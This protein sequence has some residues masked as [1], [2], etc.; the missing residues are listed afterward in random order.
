MVISVIL[1]QRFP[2]ILCATEFEVTQIFE[3]QI[4]GNSTVKSFATEIHGEFYPISMRILV[5]Y[6]TTW[7]FSLE[8]SHKCIASETT[9]Y[10]Y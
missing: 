6:L 9:Y 4:P 1:I 7:Y 10:L 5:T 2:G 3:K 8:F